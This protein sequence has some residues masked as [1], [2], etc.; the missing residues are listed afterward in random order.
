LKAK[1][2]RT[3]IFLGVL[4]LIESVLR[5]VFFYVGTHGGQLIT[6]APPVDVMQFINYF[7][8]GLGLIGLV[9]FSGLIFETSWGF[10]GSL[11]LCLATIVFDSWA[12]ATTAETALAGIIVPVL[13]LAYVIPKHSLFLVHGAVPAVRG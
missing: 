4:A 2:T 8:L 3:L 9:A 12:V 1:P 10:W 7:S 13:L 6:P 11:M 5:L